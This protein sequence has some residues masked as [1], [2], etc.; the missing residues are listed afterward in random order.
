MLPAV[1]LAV[2]LQRVAQLSSHPSHL[3]AVPSVVPALTFMQQEFGEITQFAAIWVISLCSC[4]NP[5]ACMRGRS[6]MAVRTRSC[7]QRRVFPSPLNALRQLQMQLQ[8]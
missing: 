3:Y 2:M 6:S 4:M 7:R 1:K 8:F 5:D